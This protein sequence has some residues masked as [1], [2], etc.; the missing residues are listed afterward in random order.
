MRCLIV[1]DEV[2]CREFVATLLQEVGECDQATTGEEAVAMF[3]EGLEGG[4]PY[5]LVLLD[6]MMP[7]QSGHEAAKA[8]RAFEKE[9]KPEKKVNIVMLTALNSANDAMES[10]CHAQSAA[11]L[12][13]PVSKDG[14]FNVVSKL[15]LM[16]KK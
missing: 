3:Q 11:Y 7:G 13:K 12:V 4:K 2:F 9:F 6:I 1:D 10:F 14:L 5:D 15:G 16:K 8:I